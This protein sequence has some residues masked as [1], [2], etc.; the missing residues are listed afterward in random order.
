MPDALEKR[1]KTY[2]L[3]AVECGEAFRKNGNPQLCGIPKMLVTSL[4]FGQPSQYM[5]VRD[6]AEELEHVAHWGMLDL[7]WAQV[8]L[9]LSDISLSS[10]LANQKVA[11]EAP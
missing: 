7:S 9:D 5:A 1:F 4:W 8:F 2:I 10:A 6:R 3:G 11:C